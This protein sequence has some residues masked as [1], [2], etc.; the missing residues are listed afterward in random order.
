MRGHGARDPS[1]STRDRPRCGDI[2]SR[3]LLIAGR[4]DASTSAALF[5]LPTLAQAAELTADQLEPIGAGLQGLELGD[6]ADL[7]GDDPVA[8]IRTSVAGAS[9]AAFLVSSDDLNRS[10]V[11]AVAAELD[12]RIR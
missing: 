1:G 6:L 9:D 5:L 2:R 4:D 7:P 10:Q 8:L 11:E 3:V 12:G